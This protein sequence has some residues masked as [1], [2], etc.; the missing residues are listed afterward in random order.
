MII[1]FTSEQFTTLKNEA[2]RQNKAIAR[3]INEVVEKYLKDNLN[4]REN[5]RTENIGGSQ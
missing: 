5:D 1:N 4:K 3:L 2:N